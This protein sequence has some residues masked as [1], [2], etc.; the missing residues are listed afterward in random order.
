MFESN[1][2]GRTHIYKL[3]LVSGQ[4][5]AGVWPSVR[6]VH[7]FYSI[8]LAGGAPR[9]V[10]R[11]DGAWALPARIIFSAGARHLY[12]TVTQADSDIWMIALQR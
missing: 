1:R 10:L 2:A 5:T 6:C 7:A 8:P 12:F 3:S 9:P 4:P 11:L